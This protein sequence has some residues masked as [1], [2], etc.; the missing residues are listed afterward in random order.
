MRALLLVALPLLGCGADLRRTSDGGLAA[1]ADVT[2]S[3]A[4]GPCPA[5]VAPGVACAVGTRPCLGD[6]RCNDCFCTAGVWVCGARVCVDAGACPAA[7]PRTGDACAT[8]GQSCAYGAGCAG[9]DCVCAGGRW[10][11]NAF[12]CGDR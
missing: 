2:A 8:A 5:R 11:C 12:F 6:D 10:S 3:D 7:R 9:A 4:T 1:P